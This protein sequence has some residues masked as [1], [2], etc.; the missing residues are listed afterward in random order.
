MQEVAA[1]TR[2]QTSEQNEQ[3]Q[4]KMTARNVLHML[5]AQRAQ[6][7]RFHSSVASLLMPLHVNRCDM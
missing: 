7:R 1:A 2:R 6:Q 3:Q 5:N 4:R